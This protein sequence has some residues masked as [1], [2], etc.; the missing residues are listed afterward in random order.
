MYNCRYCGKEFVNRGQLA[1]HTRFCDNNPNR[2]TNINY[3]CQFCGRVCVGID[4]LHNH[5]NHCNSNPHKKQRKNYSRNPDYV[6]SEYNRPQEC[7]CSFCGKLCKNLNSLKNH[8]KRCKNNPDKLSQVKPINFTFKGRT[9][10]NKGL[11]KE[12]DIRVAKNA[13]AIKRYY[14]T[15]DGVFKGKQHTEETKLR[16]SVKVTELDHSNHNR[17]S[18][19][20]KGWYDNKFFMST[21]ELAYYIFMRD[22]GHIINR[23]TQRFK[24]FYKDKY[25]YYTPDFVV[26][27]ADIVEVKG[28]E[29]EVDKVKY[30]VVPNLIVV[31]YDKIQS[32]IDY[33]KLKYDVENIETL[34]EISY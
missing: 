30:L 1:S 9:P 29:R 14:Q 17:Y 12:T 26:D 34:Y 28:L 33:V 22:N 20:K 31:K 4:K 24:Y 16:I 7:F 13:E 15:H 25:H 8:E 18:Y 3:N 32:M 27:N 23:C 5:E 6:I 2:T 10:Y 11:T 21:Y 19:G